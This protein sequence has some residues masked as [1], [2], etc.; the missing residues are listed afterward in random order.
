MTCDCYHNIESARSNI[1]IGRS[2][3]P[4]FSTLRRLRRTSGST[5]LE[6]NAKQRVTIDTLAN[7]TVKEL[8]ERQRTEKDSGVGWWTTARSA[9]TDDNQQ[10]LDTALYG[11]FER[12]WPNLTP[13]I[14]DRLLTPVLNNPIWDLRHCS[15]ENATGKR[16]H[17]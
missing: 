12:K 7:N 1:W 8:N 16:N 9:L 17:K 6:K 2:E 15:S 4:R 11:L 10:A 5:K 14:R 3:H 13:L